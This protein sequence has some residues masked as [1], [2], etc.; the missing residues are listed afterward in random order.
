MMESSSVM[1]KGYNMMTRCGISD[2]AWD[3]GGVMYLTYDEVEFASNLLN[4]IRSFETPHVLDK[5]SLGSMATTTIL[6]A[7]FFR[8]NFEIIGIVL[9]N[10][11]FF[12]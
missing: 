10:S 9:T 4:I 1:R 11:C 6:Q 12:G 5:E 2:Y 3:P 8:N 7:N